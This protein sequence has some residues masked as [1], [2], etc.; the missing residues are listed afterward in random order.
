MVDNTYKREPATAPYNFIPYDAARLVPAEEGNRC[1]SGTIHCC[2]EAL[3]PLF[4]GGKTKKE[5]DQVAQKYFFK[6]NGK[7]VIPGTSLKGMLRHMVEIMSQSHMSPVNK[8]KIFWRDVVGRPTGGYKTFFNSEPREGEGILSNTGGFLKSVDSRYKLFPANVER[9]DGPNAY[10][11]G[12]LKNKPFRQGYIFSPKSNAPGLDVPQSVMDW[13]EEQLT[14][15]Q[16]KR[17]KKEKKNL[18]RG[19]ARVFYA[20]DEQGQVKGIGT[21]RYFRIPYIRTVANLLGPCP[22]HDFASTL[23]GRTGKR[24]DGTDATCKGRVA[25]EAAHFTHCVEQS[26]PTRVVLQ[27]PHPSYLPH[28]ICQ[29]ADRF[30]RQKGKDALTSYNDDNV[31]LRGRKYYWHRDPARSLSGHIANFKVAADLYPVQKGARASFV[32]HVNDVNGIELGAI[33]E[34]LCLPEGHAHKLGMGKALGFGSVRITVERVEVYRPGERYASL[35]QRFANLAVPAMTREEQ[36]GLRDDFKK[37]VARHAGCDFEK[38][39][40]IRTLRCMTDFEHKPHNALTESMQRF[41]FQN[42]VP[43]PTALEVVRQK[44]GNSMAGKGHWQR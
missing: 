8:R 11:T 30:A 12:E 22:E 25:V 19:G 36:A 39:E 35:K 27:E 24:A 2:L 10:K 7:C 23:F 20:L 15:D 16:E 44:P 43:L 4:I 37:H 34:A 13:F 29:S 18:G 17:W 40:S 3:G 33:L 26:S 28:Y 32:I 14:T 9:G 41:R 1:Y 6:V 42:N 31:C 38:L 21:A 5:D